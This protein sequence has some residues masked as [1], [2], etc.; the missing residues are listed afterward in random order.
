M[1]IVMDKMAKDAFEAKIAQQDS[2]TFAGIQQNSGKDYWLVASHSDKLINSRMYKPSELQKL[3]DTYLHPYPKPVLLHH[4]DT[5]EP[6]G[7]II[8]AQYIPASNWQHAQELLGEEIPLPVDSSGALLLKSRITDPEAIQ[9][10]DDGR[11]M[12]VS[13]GF[14]ASSLKC[15]ICGQDWVADGPCEHE[16]GQ[17]YDGQL[18][19]GM[20]EG[21][22][23]ME[24]SFVNVPADDYAQVIKASDAID[25][26]N[27]DAETYTFIGKS[28]SETTVLFA[29]S[30]NLALAT[31]GVT[32]YIKEDHKESEEK[33]KMAEKA[34]K[35]TKNSKAEPAV[36]IDTASE[37]SI[38]ELSND[39]K[40]VQDALAQL[41]RMQ[42]VNYNTISGVETDGLEETFDISSLVDALAKSKQSADEFLKAELADASE[43]DT[44]K[45]DADVQADK[46][47]EDV[48][49]GK[50]EVQEAN[51]TVA[52]DAVA[53]NLQHITDA[54][55]TLQKEMLDSLKNVATVM[56]KVLDKLG[57]ESAEDADETSSEKT[58]EVAEQ[59]D[60]TDSKQGITEQQDASTTTVVKET[61]PAAA[62]AVD[63]ENSKPR[64]LKEIFS[65]TFRS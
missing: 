43:E 26:I 21:M 28:A 50:T 12:T 42:I 54:L 20:P 62:P 6:V 10:I 37:V 15:S 19:Y 49:K 17:M 8:D 38:A 24:I 51:T 11:Y 65:R 34:K 64:T 47:S 55:A 52:S 41:I 30:V 39:L 25:E 1:K 13:I 18:A 48:V 29:D 22:H 61:S 59:E 56:S 40:N 36:A 7:R 44:V 46:A 23:A 53:E 57:K 32:S 14:A 3:G 63:N 5:S 58:S 4:N 35:Q 27:K 31:C 60:K 2:A 9:K 16:F 33:G 45:E